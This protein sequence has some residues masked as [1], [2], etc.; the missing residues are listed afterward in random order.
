MLSSPAYDVPSLLLPLELLATLLKPLMPTVA[1]RYPSIRGKRSHDPS[2][3][4]AVASDPLIVNKATPRFYVEF[5]KMNRYFREN[6]EQI[7]LPTLILQ[8][9]ADGI[10]KPE[11]A[12]HLY[13]RL[14]HPKKKLIVYEN[15]YHEVFNE[16][17]R[18]KVVTDLVA[19]LDGLC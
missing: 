12:Q 1:I 6:V 15:Y 10:V 2:V 7:V 9:G 13:G 8:A 17:G 3:D 4:L 11:G 5:R 18:E 16:I 19:W 14:T